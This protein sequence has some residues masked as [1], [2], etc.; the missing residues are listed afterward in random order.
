VVGPFNELAYA[1]AQAVIENPGTSYNPLFIYG[2]TGL[3]KTHMTQAIGNTIKAKHPNKKIFY[4]KG[5]P[6]NMKAET[7]TL[8]ESGFFNIPEEPTDDYTD[9]NRI[10]NHGLVIIG[11]TPGM[12]GLKDILDAV[13]QKRIPLIVYTKERLEDAD[14]ALLE[15]YPWY[16]LCNVPLRVISDAYTIL[17]IFPLPNYDK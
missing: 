11:Y 12:Q 1:V 16:S 8:R 2:G 17:S 9:C 3:G 5:Q 14:K 7:K 6:L 10:E 15:T 4:A 13:K